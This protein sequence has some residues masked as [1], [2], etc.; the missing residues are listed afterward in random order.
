MNFN[1]YYNNTEFRRNT[2]QNRWRVGVDQR[3]SSDRFFIDAFGG[4]AGTIPLSILT[5]GNVGI[6]ILAPAYK[7]GVAGDIN[8][9]GQV[10]ANGVGLTSDARF[11]QQV[12]P[13]GGALAAVRALR[14]VRYTWNAL[15]I[16]H[17]GQAGAE[18]VGVLAQE[19]E[20]VLP[21]LVS[22]GADGY[23]AVN[24]AQLTP[25]LIEAIKE[26]QQIE[27]LKVQNAAL[28]GRTAQAD[29]DHVSLLTLQAQMARLL[30]EAAP[31]GTQARK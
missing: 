12:R 13:L 27:A 24:Y 3:G 14:G 21:E 9:P 25:V 20:K 6:G 31:A 8:A 15:G 2:G 28:H 4:T 22:T 29:A 18:Q 19:L 5:N 7:L 26:Q 16:R 17:G 1:G 11:K 23:K 10:R 30:G